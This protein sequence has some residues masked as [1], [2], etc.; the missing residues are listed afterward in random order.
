VRTSIT[1][2]LLDAEEPAAAVPCA[3]AAAAA[4]RHAAAKAA[5]LIMVVCNPHG[6]WVNI[7]EFTFFSLW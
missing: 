7:L 6:V 2:N 5:V 3:D 4:K 1:P